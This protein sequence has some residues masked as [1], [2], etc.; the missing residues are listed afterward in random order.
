[1][2]HQVHNL[3]ADIESHVVC[4]DTQNLEQFALANIHS[5]ESWSVLSN[6]RRRRIKGV[7]RMTQLF[8]L[9]QTC[10]RIRPTI[11]HSHFGNTGYYNSWIIRRTGIKHVVTFYG[12]DVNM[13]PTRYPC[14]RA[15]YRALFRSAH[16]ILCEG[17]HM[18]RCIVRLGCPTAKVRV[19]HLGVE[20]DKIIFRPRKWNSGT[21]LRVL[22]AATFRPKKGIPDALE[23]LGRF[24]QVMPLEVTIVGAAT[25]DP[26]SLDEKQRILDVIH[27]HRLEE[28]VKMLGFQRPEKLMAEAY[29]HHVFLSP[30]LTA[31]DGDTEGGAPVSLIEMAA[32]GM[33][34]ISTNHCDIPNVVK[35]LETG[36]LA[37]ERDVD[38]L[39][40]G[41]HWWIGRSTEWQ[42]FLKLGR[43]RMEQLFD[44]RT[45]ARRLAELY[46]ELVA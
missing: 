11:V 3:P 46:R 12:L 29:Q 21:R 1:M 9:W 30:S 31:P 24:R 44:V 36:W 32:S 35:H 33:P 22:I 43:E 14:W 10:S 7:K 40:G 8:W 23:A 27:R 26:A 37:D 18:A 5:L 13:L 4:D 2:Y 19:Q 42:K 25:Q 16:L 34:I 15:R 20:V 41:L 6:F 38:G 39:V 28:V 45:Q 17:P